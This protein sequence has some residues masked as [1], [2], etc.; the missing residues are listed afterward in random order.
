MKAFLVD[1]DTRLLQMLQMQLELHGFQ[2]KTTSDSVTAA[3][4]A[5]SFNPDIIISDLQMPEVD[6]FL[7][8]KQVMD[9]P[10]LREIPFIFLTS[11]D[12]EENLLEGYNLEINDYIQKT[13]S[14]RLLIKKIE[15]VLQNRT[16]LKQSA[17][18]ELKKA[19]SLVSH[20][21]E[22][23]QQI[24]DNF[25]ISIICRPFADTPGGDFVEKIDLISGQTLYII[26]DVMGKEWEAWFHSFPFKSHIKAAVSEQQQ[27]GG[28]FDA[29][30]VLD[31]LNKIITSDGLLANYS[32]AITLLVV[33]LHQSSV[34]IAGAG[35]LPLFWIRQNGMVEEV[36]PIE[37]AP[38]F[39]RKTV[40][41]SRVVFPEKGER[42]L[43]FTDGIIES[44]GN[45]SLNLYQELK[46]LLAEHPGYESLEWLEKEIKSLA[47][48]EASDDVTLLEIRRNY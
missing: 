3:R 8:R 11:N 23:Q 4:T 39:S 44:A 2:C 38:G 12:E 43:A 41:T 42:L 17:K 25:T 40:Y 32:I 15:T 9:N 37:A 16:L 36:D 26:A 18:Q 29:A 30:A 13:T 6:G 7:F 5:E 35:S 19:A 22:E 21:P 10:L 27:K 33:D 48:F 28:A 24:A 1:D 20:Q 14:P 47:G 34:Q 31:A 45:N 46:N